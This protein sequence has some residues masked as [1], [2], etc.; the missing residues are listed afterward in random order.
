MPI[1]MLHDNKFSKAQ[2]IYGLKIYIIQQTLI[3]QRAK[4]NKVYDVETEADV[5]RGIAV[6][7]VNQLNEHGKLR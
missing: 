1:N 6:S 2:K 5:A 3:A 7:A 4:R